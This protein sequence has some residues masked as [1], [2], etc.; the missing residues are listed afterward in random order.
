M[1]GFQDDKREQACLYYANCMLHSAKSEWFS[2]HELHEHLL[3]QTH[4][5]MRGDWRMHELELENTMYIN[6]RLRELDPLE[7]DDQEELEQ[8]KKWQAS[9][10]H[11]QTAESSQSSQV[12]EKI[13]KTTPEPEYEPPVIT[14]SDNPDGLDPDITFDP[15]S[16]W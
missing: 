9:M 3:E 8:L 4:R 2:W 5:A 7:P 6:Q 1:L 14:N 16:K 12:I 13:E 15:M 10:S 11:V